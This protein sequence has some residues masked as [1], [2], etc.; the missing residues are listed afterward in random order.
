MNVT[1]CHKCGGWGEVKDS[2]PRANHKYRR[3]ICKECGARWTTR[4]LRIEELDDILKVRDL[5]RNIA[6]LMPRI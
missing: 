4:E 3:R 6:E 1:A 2:R 5:I